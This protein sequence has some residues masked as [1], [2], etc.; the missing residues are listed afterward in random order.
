MYFTISPTATAQPDTTE[1][2]SCMATNRGTMTQAQYYNKHNI[3]TS[4]ILH[5]A[6]Y[7]NK[8]N[9]TWSTILHQAQYYN[10][11][12]I[13]WSTILQQ[14]QYYQVPIQQKQQCESD[15]ATEL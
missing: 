15:L 13:T 11:H 2:S 10:K 6:Q 9:I 5:Q 4:T 14:A 1:T 7:Y 3:T 8:H 12:N